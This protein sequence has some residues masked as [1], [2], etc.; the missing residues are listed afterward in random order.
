MVVEP[1]KLEFFEK[2]FLEDFLGGKTPHIH[3][4]PIPI[5]NFYQEGF[6]GGDFLH[7]DHRP[8][9]IIDLRLLRPLFPA[10][11]PLRLR[12]HRERT[13]PPPGGVKTA[14]A[15]TTWTTAGRSTPA[16]TTA[17]MRLWSSRI[18]PF[19]PVGFSIRC[20]GCSDLN[21]LGSNLGLNLGLYEVFGVCFWE[22]FFRGL[23][24]WTQ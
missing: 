8:T 18:L 22:R 20:R 16:T 14:P 21:L 2:V 6:W 17:L 7:G 23:F 24:S 9:L 13:P 12:A 19:P 4:R 1:P 10:S 5:I 11:R 3:P 15:A